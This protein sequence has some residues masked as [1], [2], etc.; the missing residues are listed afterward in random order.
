M[1]I[2]I[3]TCQVLEKEI[4]SLIRDN[5]EVSHF[6]VM[7]WGLHVQPDRLLAA[8]SDQIR[9]MEDQVEA[10]VL[11]YG[12]CQAMDRLPANFKIPVFRPPAEDCLG[13]LLGQERY[14]QE[15]RKEAGTWF[16]SRGWTE[17]GMD[18]IFHEL[19][20]N[21]LAEK[22]L[23]P[24]KIAH[25]MLK[26]F[27]RGLYI[28]TGLE[29]DLRLW[30]KA[31]EISREFHLR[32]ER[33]TGSISLLKQTIEEALKEQNRHLK[34]FGGIMDLFTAIKERRSCR[35]FSTE[36]VEE[37]TLEKI[38]EA[39]I[40]A[41]SPMNAQPWEFIV[42]T[43]Q[44]GKEEI[45]AEAERCRQWALST[46]GWKWLDK[47]RVD[48]LKTAPV[49]VV[50]V[51]DPKKTGVD[52]FLEDGS[53]GYQ[54][55]CAAAVQNMMLAAQALGIGSLWYTLFDKNN[56]AQ[57]LGINPEKKPLSIVCLGKPSG[58]VPP[59]GRKPVQEK[60]AFFR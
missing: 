3:I 59:V 7:E 25:R 15:I 22:G 27:T 17:M 23:D 12:R 8:V 39:A 51:G 11:G 24:L 52:Q 10:V 32:L 41:P 49:L 1:G 33:T 38:L 19:Q 18:F 34:N 16:F 58:D 53:L 50:V 45:C 48:F 6:V 21:R 29:D 55:A 60:I 35:S 54:Y 5:P 2:G 30:P 44:E 13:V 20:V 37:A 46:S 56:L 57:I 43:S 9:K 26:D 36:P 40:W 42:V 4:K 47:Y 31:L 14:E 28:E